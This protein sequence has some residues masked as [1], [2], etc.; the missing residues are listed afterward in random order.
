MN[1]LLT[2]LILLNF[3]IPYKYDKQEVIN[4]Y[5]SYYESDYMMTA[6]V[7][8]RQH[9]EQLPEDISQYHGFIAA[10]SCDWIGETWLVK[11][12]NHRKDNKWQRMLVSDCA[13]DGTS[14][15]WMRDNNILVEFGAIEAKRYGVYGNTPIRI[16]VMKLKTN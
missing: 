12:T 5:A 13:G 8:A 4:G 9:N 7:V 2:I 16:A 6:T 1:Y 10:L 14:F 3:V 11:V 15:A